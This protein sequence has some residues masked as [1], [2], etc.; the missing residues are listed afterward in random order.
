MVKLIFLLL[1]VANATFGQA[2]VVGQWNTVDDASGEIKA[3]VELTE[4]KGTVNG[5]IVRIFDKEHPDPVCEECAE[6]D[7]RF[8]KKIVGMGIIR[9]LKGE[10]G[11]FGGGQI[12]DPENGRVYQCRIWIEDG[13]LMVRG[14]WGPFHRTQK[15]R[16]SSQNTTVL[17]PKS[18]N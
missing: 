10:D 17:T 6:D 12:L 1:L 16:R 7:D 3:I 9:G 8:R 13:D 2:S 14:Y 4:H 5:R 15:W 18:E 11:G